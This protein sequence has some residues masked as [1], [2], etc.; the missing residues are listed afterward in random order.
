MKQ[1][2]WRVAVWLVGM[3][4]VVFS[5]AGIHL[6]AAHQYCYNKAYKKGMPDF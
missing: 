4:G 6:M 1:I 3:P 2:F 5:W